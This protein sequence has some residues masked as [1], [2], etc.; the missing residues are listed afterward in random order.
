M[1]GI[2]FLSLPR[3]H[4]EQRPREA[5]IQRADVDGPN[6]QGQDAEGDVVALKMG[7]DGLPLSLRLDPDSE[8]EDDEESYEVQ[9]LQV[10]RSG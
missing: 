4:H 1:K 7:G 10:S 8:V 9:S 6:P 2:T 3:H 5:R